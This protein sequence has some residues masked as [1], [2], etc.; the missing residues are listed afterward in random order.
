M[1]KIQE[2]KTTKALKPETMHFVRKLVDDFYNKN[3]FS[4]SNPDD[5]KDWQNIVDDLLSSAKSNQLEK[6]MIRTRDGKQ[7][8]L[9]RY[10]LINERPKLRVT[11]HNVLLS[12]DAA[13]HD[14]PW[15]YAS[16]I[17]TGGYYEDT[18]DGRKWW[19]PGS[20]RTNSAKSLHRLEV[21]PES[22]EVWTLFFMG[23]KEKDW[24]FLKE[25]GTVQQ[26]QEYLKEQTGIWYEDQ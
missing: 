17:L 20:F 16:L 4:L 23:E 9:A 2:P 8:Y 5:N 26:W 6:R 3:S 13:L 7:D 10:Y 18:V 15:D 21:N 1:D 19:P 11:L 25:N 22:G 14:H 24:G 12:D